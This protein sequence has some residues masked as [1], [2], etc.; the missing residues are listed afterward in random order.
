MLPIKERWVL[1]IG[2]LEEKQV[3]F[4]NQKEHNST[5]SCLLT[6][7]SCMS[8]LTPWFSYWYQ[9]PTSEASCE[10]GADL[11]TLLE[12]SIYFSQGFPGGSDSKESAC[13]AGDLDSIAGSGR[14]P[15][16]GNGNPFQY[17]RLG[18][19]MD[20]GALWAIVHGIA[21]NWTRLSD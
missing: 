2:C 21:E 11:E 7:I 19:P 20:R 8:H 14:P 4:W 12:W 3:W 10:G 13:N 1:M 6:E 15:G 5:L 17:S 18:N 9:V 16:E